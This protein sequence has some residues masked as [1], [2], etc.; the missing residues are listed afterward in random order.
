MTLSMLITRSAMRMVRIAAPIVPGSLT[1][2]S[3]SVSSRSW[4]PIQSSA[5]APT[6]FRYGTCSIWTATIVSTIRITIAA[7]LP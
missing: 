7:A 2:P 4:M 5:R 3:S 1:S 6:I